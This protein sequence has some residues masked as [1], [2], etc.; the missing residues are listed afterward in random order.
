M[1]EPFDPS[2]NQPSPTAEKPSNEGVGLPPQPVIIPPSPSQTESPAVPEETSSSPLSSPPADPPGNPPSQPESTAAPPQAVPESEVTP[3]V[4]TPAPTVA[5]PPPAA[6]AEAQPV[7][8]SSSPLSEVAGADSPPSTNEPVGPPWMRTDPNV[9]ASQDGVLETNQT[10]SPQGPSE[11]ALPWQT[12][13]VQDQSVPSPEAEEKRGGFPV[14]IF[15]ILILGIIALIGV[16]L[17][18]KK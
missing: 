2:K 8:Q 14:I 11:P 18:I 9:R 1:A 15:V 4:P 13:P 12:P 16:Y 3:T 6:P 7:T 5:D 10:L 17:F